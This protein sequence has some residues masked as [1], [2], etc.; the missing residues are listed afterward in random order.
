MAKT[1]SSSASTGRRLTAVLI[2]TLLHA[3]AFA[4]APMELD[5]LTMLDVPA[6]PDSTA[7][8][9]DS[10]FETRLDAVVAVEFGVTELY[11][12]R[13][14]ID[15]WLESD[16]SLG[17][18]LDVGGVTL[19]GRDATWLVGVAP[20]MRWRFLERD[21]WS[22]YADL[23]V[24]V[25]WTGESVPIGGT[26]FNFTPQAGIGAEFRLGSSVSGRIG[27]GWYHMSNARTGSNNPGLDAVSVSLGLSLS[28]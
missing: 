14:G 24:G 21:A 1:T 19:E 7:T 22:M 4:E 17:L 25:A 18:Q 8:P 27:L 6:P 10:S 23:G 28:F 13:G 2:A 9:T 15:W 16:F 11:L 12:A 20:I 26:S 5:V 3:R